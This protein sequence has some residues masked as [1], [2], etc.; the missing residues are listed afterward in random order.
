MTLEYQSA[1]ETKEEASS[2]V[3][4]RRFPW[5]GVVV[6]LVLAGLMMFGLQASAPNWDHQNANILT[7]LIAIVALT[8]VMVMIGRH[9][10]SS[11]K[12]ARYIL[13]LFASLAI[14]VSLVKFDGFSGEMV[15]QLSSRFGRPPQKLSTS[16]VD[17]STITEIDLSAPE[18]TATTDSVQFL[19]NDRDA[20]ISTREFAIPNSAS[21]IRE[22]WRVPV[23]EGWSSFS[24]VGDRAVTMEQRESTECVTCYRLADGEMLWINSHSARHENP[25]GGIGPRATPT[26]RDGKVYAQG[27]SGWVG[28]FDVQ[29]GNVVWT[30]DLLTLAGWDQT[31]SESAAPW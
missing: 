30:V 27:A 25:M 19:G 22:L 15:P 4:G 31:A 23:G 29:T 1:V 2:P 9:Q 3:N 21:E 18:A 28:C 11:G 12:L 17:P 13:V 26:I 7:G 14:A 16:S 5:V 24:V 10:F 8:I 6:T 20:T